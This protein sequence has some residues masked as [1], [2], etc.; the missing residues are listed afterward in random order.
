MAM[1]LAMQNLEILSCE[2]LPVGYTSN[3]QD[4]DDNDAETYPNA[5]E[6]C[7]DGLDN[8]CDSAIDENTAVNASVFYLDDDGDGYGGSLY[9]TQC[10]SPSSL[11]FRFRRLS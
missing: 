5:L 2:G 1:V 10:Q 7:H 6:Y 11:Y 9:V 4:C 8:N 3:N